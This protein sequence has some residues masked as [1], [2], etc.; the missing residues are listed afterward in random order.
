MKKKNA[1]DREKKAEMEENKKKREKSKKEKTD[2]A[3]DI[4]A[5]VS[6]MS[7]PQ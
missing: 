5:D 2:E 3:F 1:Y 6:Q 4:N 7:L